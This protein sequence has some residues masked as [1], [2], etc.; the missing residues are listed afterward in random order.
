MAILIFF[1]GVVTPLFFRIGVVPTCPRAV[2]PSCS[3]TLVQSCFRAIVPSCHRKVVP[4]PF[5]GT[6]STQGFIG[7]PEIARPAL[8]EFAFLP[9]GFHPVDSK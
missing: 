1:G 3:R 9:D 7:L 2:V 6:S 4:F 8:H 5:H